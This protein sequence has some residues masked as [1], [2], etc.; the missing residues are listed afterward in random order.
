[1]KKVSSAQA[2]VKSAQ[3]QAKEPKSAVELS[4]IEERKESEAFDAEKDD[5]SSESSAES[6]GE[7]DE[8]FGEP[9]LFARSEA[10]KLELSLEKVMGATIEPDSRS[11]RSEQ[12]PQ[13]Q[14]QVLRLL[15]PE[16][17]AQMAEIEKAGEPIATA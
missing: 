6:L 15:S 16:Q 13:S 14:H 2:P 10:E 4:A 7:P 1:M 17:E 9:R 3:A 5:S 12:E 11:E 8:D